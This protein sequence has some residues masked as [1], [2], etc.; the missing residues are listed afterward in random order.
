[1]N[2]PTPCTH[3]HNAGAT[4]YNKGCRCPRCVDAKAQ[5]RR[6]NY[7]KNPERYRAYSKANRLKYRKPP[8]PRP[9]YTPLRPQCEYPQYSP[10]TSWDYGCRCP[11]CVTTH[12]HN[13]AVYRRGVIP[14][15]KDALRARAKKT[16][17]PVPSCPEQYKAL[18]KVYI[19]SQI[20]IRDGIPCHVDHIVPLEHGGTHT[21]DNVRLLDPD[22]NVARRYTP[23]L[24]CVPLVLSTPEQLREY[25]QTLKKLG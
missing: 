6:R 21:A 22:T 16:G 3:P 13:R 9:L 1:M 4:G 23:D 15:A 8:V 18:L 20:L 19:Q 10:Y 2:T 14:C 24:P 5:N 11:D 7:R 17:V 12:K 25:T